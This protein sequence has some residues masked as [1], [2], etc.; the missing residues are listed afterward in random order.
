MMS[1]EW[2]PKIQETFGSEGG[3]FGDS[4]DYLCKMPGSLVLMNQKSSYKSS[5]N[6]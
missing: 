1:A 5:N 4:V 6:F 3:G 2:M